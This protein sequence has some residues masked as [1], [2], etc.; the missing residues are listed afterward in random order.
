[1]KQNPDD[2][3]LPRKTAAAVTARLEAFYRFDAPGPGGPLPKAFLKAWARD[4]DKETADLLKFVR[5]NKLIDEP[6]TGKL[7]DEVAVFFAPYG[8]AMQALCPLW[9]AASYLGATLTS[10]KSQRYT[11]GQILQAPVRKEDR[12][13]FLKTLRALA[14]PRVHPIID[15][16]LTPQ[17]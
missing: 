6:G 1:M 14:H 16:R 5:C 2:E 3:R 15:A 12:R 4:Y 10:L 8:R 17:K 7:L 13:A 9:V 11:L